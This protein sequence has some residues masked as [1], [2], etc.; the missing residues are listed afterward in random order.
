MPI[1]K[2]AL[3]CRLY[4]LREDLPADY[5][6]KFP[7]QLKRFWFKEI[8]PKSG[9][10]RST[11]WSHP[12]QILD[13]EADWDALHFHPWVVLGLRRDRKALNAVMF[14][15]RKEQAVLKALADQERKK[16]TKQERKAIEEQVRMDMLAVQTP[17]TTIY[18][19]SWNLSSGLVIFAASSA[20]ANT[21]FCDLFEETFGLYLWPML[22]YTLA[23]E[24][25][26]SQGDER[27]LESVW[28]ADFTT[29]KATDLSQALEEVKSLI[30]KGG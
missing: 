15:A 27:I 25:S 26:E 4:R 13:P 24:Y 3:S 28:P 22:P 1:S 14:R 9:E 20:A 30:P 19:A 11:G 17:A 10:D 16:L 6:E 5:T 12:R 29:R 23:E 21:L 8:D 2:G 18:E 7:L